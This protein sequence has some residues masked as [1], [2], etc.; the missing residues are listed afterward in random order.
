MQTPWEK[1]CQ[2]VARVFGSNRSLCVGSERA[3]AMLTLM[4]CIA[5]DR[6]GRRVAK[7]EGDFG[8][9][10]WFWLTDG[11]CDNWAKARTKQHPNRLFSSI[12]RA[13]DSSPE[14]R[15]FKSG[16]GHNTVILNTQPE[17]VEFLKTEN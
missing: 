8:V 5:L 10:W 9:G 4:F 17:K 7:C 12:G 6:T 2:I 15:Q 1:E 16:K 11:V 3:P 14:G 13:S